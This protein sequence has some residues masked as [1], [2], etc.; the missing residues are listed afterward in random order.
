MNPQSSGKRLIRIALLAVFSVGVVLLVLQSRLRAALGGTLQS[1]AK[2]LVAL[3]M[4]FNGSQ[5]CAGESCHGAAN[6]AADATARHGDE[7]T[8]WKTKDKHS[9]AYQTLTDDPQSAAIAKKLGLASAA[10]SEECLS[11]HSLSVPAALQGDNF[12][13]K[14]GVTCNACHGPSANWVGAHKQAGWLDTQR[15]AIPD[16]DALLQKLGIYDTKPIL[17]RADRCTSCHLA[18]DSKLVAAGHPQ[19]VFELAYFS[20]IEPKHWRE[21]DGLF[22]TKLWATGQS[23]CL[24]D[25]LVQ[26]ADRV[27]AGVD[28][29]SAVE[30]VQ[31]HYVMFKEAAGVVDSA[32]AA[33]LDAEITPEFTAP[34][35]KA[36]QAAA[37][38]DALAVTISKHD[39]T[40]AETVTILKAILATDAPGKIGPTAQLQQAEGI[41]ELYNATDP[42][43]TDAAAA[44][45]AGNLPPP[46][47][48]KPS[49]PL[50][51]F[52]KN[53]ADARAK[54]HP[55]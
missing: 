43:A 4:K 33:K 13:V 10:T 26:L 6:P 17:A 44:T 49:G 20:E 22:A 40:Q 48:K 29:K 45:S 46:S 19:P 28:T 16:H 9:S 34:D 52:D 23:V 25:A 5:T 14:E 36:A 2:S 47:D 37:D 39:F 50:V 38:V 3:N 41:Y 18:M 12:N 53:L 8:V 27:T 21:P 15:A 30:Q 1:P 11:C 24:R 51:D 7:F 54:I 35:A 55:K 31:G 32:A 42:G